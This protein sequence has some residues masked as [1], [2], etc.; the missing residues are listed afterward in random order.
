MVE[1]IRQWTYASKSEK[2][3]VSSIPVLTKISNVKV[4]KGMFRQEMS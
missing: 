1:A 2:K 3:I 4:E